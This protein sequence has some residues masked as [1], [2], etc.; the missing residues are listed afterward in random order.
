MIIWWG[1]NYNGVSINLL[2]EKQKGFTLRLLELTDTQL[3]EFPILL[4]SLYGHPKNFGIYFT[5]ILFAA[6]IGIA[7]VILYTK[8]L[9]ESS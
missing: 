6:D 7:G 1:D 2:I 9:L 3:R 4:N 8:E 5:V